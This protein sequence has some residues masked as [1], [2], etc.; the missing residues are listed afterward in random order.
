VAFV[1]NDPEL[2]VRL[3]GAIQIGAGALLATGRFRRLASVTLMGSIIANTW[4]CHRFWE[5]SDEEVRAQHRAHFLKNLGL[6]GGLILSTMDTEGEPSLAW[7]AKRRA[8]RLEAAVGLGRAAGTAKARST[9]SDALTTAS[10]AAKHS[11]RK[12]RKASV[13]VRRAARRANAAGLDSGRQAGKNAA[14]AA[15]QATV[16]AASTLREAK[17]AALSVAH[18]GAEL[19]APYVATGAE[20]AGDLLTK[21]GEQLVNH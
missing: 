10:A 5:E 1:P 21:V 16:V 20:L 7:R 9:A 2:L 11:K 8:H 6:L 3:D 17:P 14:T 15:R 19:A 12:V 4:A 13:G 18:S